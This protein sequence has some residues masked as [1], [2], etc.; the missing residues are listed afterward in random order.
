MSK[1]KRTPRPEQVSGP[2]QPWRLFVRDGTWRTGWL[3]A[4]SLAVLAAVLLGLRGGLEAL[5]VRLFTAW[6]L[7]ADN[8]AR[9]PGW[10]RLLY[11]CRDGLVTLITAGALLALCAPLR[12]LWGL[13]PDG[14]RS[15]RQGWKG[16]LAGTGTALLIAALSLVPDSSRFSWSLASPR[17]SGALP[18]LCLVSFAG[19]LAEEAFIRRVLQDGLRNRWGSHWALAISCIA[20]FL[21]RAGWTGGVVYMANVLLTGLVCGLMVA[22][23]GLWAG[24]GFRWGLEAAAAY[25]LGFGG[26][27][28]AIYRLYDVSERLWTGGDAGPLYGLWLTLALIGLALWGIR[29]T[30]PK[31]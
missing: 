8:V 27:N 17:F 29:K 30:H 31:H 16:L 18:G 5:S 20:F 25:L 1:S 21:M 23:F 3:L 26:G 4:T 19:V 15:V 2:R 6:N 28:A 13:G 12:R 24:V 10:A 14:R 7:R 22:R 11:A 9:A